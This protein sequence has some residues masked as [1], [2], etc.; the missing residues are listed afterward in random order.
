MNYEEYEKKL[1]KLKEDVEWKTHR[2]KLA[3]ME[4]EVWESFFN[5][6]TK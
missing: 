1:D 4:L 2:L 6:V 5:R 3:E